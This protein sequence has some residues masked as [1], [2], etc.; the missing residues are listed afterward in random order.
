MSIYTSDDKN[1]EVVRLPS[2]FVAGAQKAGTTSLHHWLSQQLGVFLPR[3][4]ETHFFSSDEQYAKGLD[5]Y[6]KQFPD[7]NNIGIIGEVSPDYMFSQKAPERIHQLVPEAR[8]IFIFR[9]PIQRA[10][11]HYFMAVRNGYETLSFYD[12][13]MEEPERMRKGGEFSSRYSYL[14]RGLYSK[15][16]NE[17]KKYFSDSSCMFIK[18]DDLVAKEG[19]NIDLL[20]KVASFIGLD[21]AIIES[22]KPMGKNNPS[23]VPYSSFLRNTLYKKSKLKSLL[24][25]LIPSRDLRATIAHKVDLLNQRAVSKP[26]IGK[27]PGETL[28]AAATE[29]GVLQSLTGLELQ[30]WLECISRYKT[31]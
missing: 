30:D 1:T 10:Y 11:S 23:S 28:L 26:D 4:K 19:N 2:F 9:E 7:G 3:N 12:A 24:R 31:D 6:L 27:I 8:L 15:Q 20:K 17:Y 18:F 29:V 21:P 13:L 22:E 14:S 5:W 16:I 25:V